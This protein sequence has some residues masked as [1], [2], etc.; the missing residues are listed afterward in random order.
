MLPKAAVRFG[1][2]RIGPIG[3]T[4]DEDVDDV[5]EEGGQGV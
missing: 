5:R 1:Q 4:G 3:W 2:L